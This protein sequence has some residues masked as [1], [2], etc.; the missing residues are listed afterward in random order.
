MTS[1][2]QVRRGSTANVWR[3]TPCSRYR[4]G[5]TAR[6]AVVT[7]GGDEGC[8]ELM[9]LW[10]PTRVAQ[11]N[12]TEEA[13]RCRTMRDCARYV[14][15]LESPCSRYQ[16][17]DAPPRVAVVSTGDGG[18]TKLVPT[19]T[20]S[21]GSSFPAAAA[22]PSPWTTVRGVYGYALR[23]SPC[24]LH[25]PGNA[26]PLAAVVRIGDGGCTRRMPT[27]AP[28]SRTSRTT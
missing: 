10:T 15:E 19:R 7:S 20:P 9:P 14:K 25:R 2:V 22:T 16:P 3:T 18:R 26:A 5:D 13:T 28:S 27:G 21:E 17:G 4:P 12:I 1:D 24:S 23:G 6:L 8:T 11:A